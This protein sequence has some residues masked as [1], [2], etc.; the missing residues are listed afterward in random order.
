MPD[1]DAAEFRQELERRLVV[2][3]DP[4]YDD[5]AMADL[6]TRDL[7]ALLIGGIVVIVAL[8]VWGY[9]W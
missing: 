1:M 8:L 9:P 2:L 7:L 5:P 6:P 4:A 3:E